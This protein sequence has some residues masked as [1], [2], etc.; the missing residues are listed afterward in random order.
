ML[1]VNSDE[2]VA[3]EFNAIEKFG[4]F[5]RGE[6]KVKAR[7]ADPAVTPKTPP[8]LPSAA[9]CSERIC[10]QGLFKHP[11]RVNLSLALL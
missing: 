10:W 2:T 8:S 4:N 11:E 5:S 6:G 1:D 9:L 7:L 3:S